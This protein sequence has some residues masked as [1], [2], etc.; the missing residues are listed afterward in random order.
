MD[1]THGNS[2]NENGIDDAS[3]EDDDEEATLL[4]G[5]PWRKRAVI[6]KKFLMPLVVLRQW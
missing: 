6:R 3:S 1:K 4:V 5:L 2:N